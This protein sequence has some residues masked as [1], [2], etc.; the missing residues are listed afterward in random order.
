MFQFPIFRISYCSADATYDR[1][2]AFIATNKNETLECHAF[3]CP[4]RKMVKI[5]SLHKDMTFSQGRDGYDNLVIIF[6]SERRKKRVNS[7]KD[8]R[9]HPAYKGGKSA[10]VRVG[11]EC[12]I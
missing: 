5:A 6:C 9:P 11:P 2:F 4:K 12:K 8:K 10:L 7:I 3:L 1:V